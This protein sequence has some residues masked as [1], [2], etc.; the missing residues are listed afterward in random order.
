MN[1]YT[2]NIIGAGKLGKAIGKLLADSNKCSIQG[3]VNSNIESSQKAIEFINQGKAYSSIQELPLADITFITTPD[4]LIQI[5]C[6]KLVKNNKIKSNSIVIHCSGI[7]NIDALNSAKNLKSLNNLDKL[8]KKVNVYTAS[9][10]PVKSFADSLMAVNNFK[11][12]YCAFE[13][14]E[15]TY[16]II[17]P[18]FDSFG[19]IIFKVN[20]EQKEL[21]HAACVIASNYTVTLTDMAKKCFQDSGLSEQMALNLANKLVLNAANNIKK[22]NSTDLA[23]TGP[24]D[25]EELSTIKKHL[26]ALHNK[27]I[28][29]AYIIL[30]RNTICLCKATLDF[31]NSLFT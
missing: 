16:N 28:K 27:H 25:R 23:L 19:S 2:V 6:D 3:I 4:D 12:T 20:S 29:K 17:K 14:C 9:I 21:Y 15:Y 26:T 31:K 1:I 8:D 13:G 18:I 11:G 22:L 5:I 30:A 10:H 24:I 7:L